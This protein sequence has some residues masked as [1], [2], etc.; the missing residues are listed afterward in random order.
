MHAEQEKDKRTVNVDMYEGLA[1]GEITGDK[2]EEIEDKVFYVKKQAN[3]TLNRD[4]FYP[5]PGGI[6]E[7]IKA[8]LSGVKILIVIRN[9]Q[10]W[11]RSNYLHRIIDLPKRNK[12]FYDYIST[13]SGKSVLFSGLYHD[14]IDTYYRLFGKEKVHV[15]LLEQLKSEQSS[16]LKKLC[17]F[18]GVDFVDFPKEKQKMNKGP[19]NRVGNG[20]KKLSSLG[21]GI[22]KDNYD[23]YNLLIRL[24]RKIKLLDRDVLTSK[25]KAFIR[26]FYAAS[27][28]HTSKFLGIDL[29]VYGYPL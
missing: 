24:C 23:R 26:S 3:S 16:E 4:Y 27:N 20:I 21:I 19:G 11:I 1:V 14:T 13:R 28:C 25:D 2:F 22:T 18:L 9:Q 5:D 6:A 15:M 8:T 17:Q 12:K 10:D 29:G 7:R